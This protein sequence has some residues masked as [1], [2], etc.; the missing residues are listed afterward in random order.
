MNYHQKFILTIIVL[1]FALEYILTTQI[2][3]S[4][5]SFLS[6]SNPNGLDPNYEKQLLFNLLLTGLNFP[7]SMMIIPIIAGVVCDA[8]GALNFQLGSFIIF[9]IGAL[10]AGTCSITIDGNSISFHKTMVIQIGIFLMG[11]SYQCVRIGVLVCLSNSFIYR[12]KNDI[13]LFIPALSAYAIAEALAYVVG[14][15]I[16]DYGSTFVGWG[17][18]F[19]P[20]LFLTI[21]TMYLLIWIL[22]ENKIMMKSFRDVQLSWKTCTNKIV[23]VDSRGETWAGRNDYLKDSDDNNLT[24]LLTKVGIPKILAVIALGYILAANE[25]TFYSPPFLFEPGLLG[26]TIP[27]ILSVVRI[28]GAFIFI[29]IKWTKYKTILCNFLLFIILSVATWQTFINEESPSMSALAVILFSLFRSIVLQLY[30]LN[31]IY[32]LDFDIGNLGKALGCGIWCVS[33]FMACNPVFYYWWIPLIALAGYMP[34]LILEV[35]KYSLS[36]PNRQMEVSEV[37]R[38]ISMSSNLNSTESRNLN[39]LDFKDSILTGNLS[40]R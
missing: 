9:N 17:W 12:A 16:A 32:I 35:K 5:K 7:N 20:V 6:V 28:V 4:L 38:G 26:E 25:Y 1:V 21:F 27:Y 2:I 31:I 37:P 15:T 11:A 39:D 33:A 22:R 40:I 8:I 14:Y 30:T 34:Y 19:L 3:F 13:Q 10:I 29:K 24:K 23:D 36:D 18:T